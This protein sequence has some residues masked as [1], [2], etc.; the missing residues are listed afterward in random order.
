ME[1][2]EL[3]SEL[4]ENNRSLAS[5]RNKYLFLKTIL[6]RCCISITE[7][8]ALQF[9]S[10]FSRLVY[11]SNKYNIPADLTW[12]LQNIRI[13]YNFLIKSDQNIISE[14]EYIIAKDSI[15]NFLDRFFK[16]NYLNN[17]SLVKDSTIDLLQKDDYLRIQITN[18]DRQKYILTGVEESENKQIFIKYNVTK[19]NDEFT[20]VLNNLWIDA[21][22]NIVDYKI[23]KF[24]FYI[25]KIIV[26]EPD[27][28]IDASAVAECFQSYGHSYLHF[29]RKRFESNSNSKHILLGNLANTFLDDLIFSKDL[30]KEVFEKRFI[31]AFKIKP[32]EFTSCQ[33]ITHKSSFIEFM[34]KARNQFE[35]I[36]RTIKNDFITNDIEI[37]NCT[38]EPSFF[39]EKYGF[40]GRLDLLQVSEDDLH[41]IE[42][43]SGGLPYPKNDPTKISINHEVQTA[44]YQ[45]ITSTVYKNKQI[46]AAILYSAADN[47]NENLRYAATYKELNKK[48]VHVRNQIIATEHSLYIGNSNDVKNLFDDICDVKNYGKERIPD[49]FSNQIN[50]FSDVIHQLND[51]EKAYFFRYISFISRDLYIHKVG[52]SSYESHASVANLWNTDFKQKLEAFNIIN[53]LV[54]ETIDEYRK[55]LKITL[56]RTDK[57]D[58][59]NFREGELCILYPQ[60]NNNDNVLTNQVMK[61]YI[62]NISENYVVLRFRYKQK[63]KKYFEI[64]KYWTVEH[65]YLDHGY[66]SMFKNLFKF[67]ETNPTKRQIILGSI[68]P[69]QTELKKYC[70]EEDIN[71]YSREERKDY[72]VNKAINA[73]N[74]FLL[75][76]PPGTGKTSQYARSLINHYYSNTSC[77]ILVIAY[78]NRAVDEL[79]ESICACFNSDSASCENYI[80]IGT[81]IS[82]N[83]KFR[84]RLLQNISSEVKSRDELNSILKKQRIFVATLASLLGKPE[85]FT[86]KKFDIA[87]IDEASQILEPQ[88]IGLL[89]QVDKFIMIGDHKQLSTIT[90]QDKSKSKVSEPILNKIKLIDCKESLF[91]RLYKLCNANNWNKN[92]D[93]LMY[94]GRMH[95]DIQK[96]PNNYFYDKILKPINEWQSKQLEYDFY[97]YTNVYSEI[98]HTKRVHFIDTSNSLNS[99]LTDKVNY[100]EAEIAIE[101]CKAIIDN[102]ELNNI[103]LSI[104]KTIGIITPYRNQIALIKH[105]ILEAEEKYKNILSQIM[106]DTVERFQGSQRDIIIISFCMNKPY[107]LDQFCNWD[108]SKLVDRKLNVA[109]TRARKQLFM[110][111]NKKIL[112]EISIYKDL[113]DSYM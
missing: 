47:K 36:K 41:I 11:I 8:S 110:I 31:E 56:R 106:I 102:Y 73:E 51:L 101:L 86:L 98:V 79:C 64:H 74:Y 105:K 84:H 58:F 23:D 52:G 24:G 96:Y 26:L 59:I 97:K 75:V 50:N 21:Q 55:D 48:I 19:I 14:K 107:Q 87:I 3:L 27:Y 81:E 12:N 40:Q 4:D 60:D 5:L 109:I 91:E 34:T 9:P 69:S 18:I 108:S 44:I 33:D 38:L 104:D 80:R 10:L 1:Y 92:F 83:E 2:S 29:F 72:I 78:T 100:K 30:N 54:I 53:N 90:L 62:E 22:L 112:D 42:L 70:I 66:T 45:L 99:I 13:K 113:T 28:L 89:A 39:C 103:E 67:F 68:N 17:I 76:G 61:G 111:G 63:N 7:E 82:C 94:Q 88:I 20:S 65:D 57:S 71:E 49:Y 93:T 95:I 25:P 35:N 15:V 37:D 6:E 43:K 46:V 16:K 85:L 32:L 77:N